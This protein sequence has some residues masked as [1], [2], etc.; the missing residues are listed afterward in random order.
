MFSLTCLPDELQLSIL[1]HLS[2]ETMLCRVE[3][4][5]RGFQQHVRGILDKNGFV[6]KSR[7]AGPGIV[8]RERMERYGYLKKMR[9]VFDNFSRLKGG[10][11]TQKELIQMYLNTASKFDKLITTTDGELRGL[12]QH[13]ERRI[14]NG[15]LINYG[16]RVAS[17]SLTGS[18]S[19]T[20][21]TA[22]G[23]KSRARNADSVSSL[24]DQF[25]VQQSRDR[26]NSTAS[27]LSSASVP[28]QKSSNRQGS[29]SSSRRGSIVAASVPRTS[30]ID[31]ADWI[32]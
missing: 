18:S 17:S 21:V 29:I 1:V 16:T 32:A 12:L 13:W 24:T 6:T 28:S 8:S 26:G 30:S 4:L 9:L 14:V 19:L 15:K 7:L 25:E 22:P 31:E 5:S 27:L 3:I 20:S 2:T 11:V 23:I 10:V